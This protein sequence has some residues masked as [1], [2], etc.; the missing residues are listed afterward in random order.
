MWEDRAI[1][2]NCRHKTSYVVHLGRP[3]PTL[4]AKN[5]ARHERVSALSLGA[6]PDVEPNGQPDLDALG[7]PLNRVLLADAVDASLAELVYLIGGDVY[8]VLDRSRLRT[9]R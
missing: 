4:F 5:G 1:V 9:G 6:A 8:D 7:E 3:Y 2:G